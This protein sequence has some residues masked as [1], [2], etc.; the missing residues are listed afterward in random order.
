M[1]V[2]MFHGND[3]TDSVQLMA[4]CPRCSGS[5]DYDCDDSTCDGTHSCTLCNGTGLKDVTEKAV[6]IDYTDHG[7]VRRARSIYPQNM[8]FGKSSL[9]E[10]PSQWFLVA[11]DFEKKAV[12]HFAMKNIYNWTEGS[13]AARGAK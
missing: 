9:H 8:F 4:P 11:Y 6:V 2:L 5:G 12:R 13:T 10:G 1:K 7:G 3:V